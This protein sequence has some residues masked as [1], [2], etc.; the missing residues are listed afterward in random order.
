MA[1]TFRNPFENGIEVIGGDGRWEKLN[2]TERSSFYAILLKAARS[3][4]DLDEEAL[5]VEALKIRKKLADRVSCFC[6]LI[7]F[8]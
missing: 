3:N 2:C 7:Y 5:T 6:H 1:H 8:L 4:E